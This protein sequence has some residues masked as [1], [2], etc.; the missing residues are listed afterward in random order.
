MKKIVLFSLLLSCLWSCQHA[1][2]SYDQTALPMSGNVEIPD[3]GLAFEENLLETHLSKLKI[4]KTGAITMEVEDFARARLQLDSMIDIHR[5][6]VANEAANRLDDKMEAQVTIKLLPQQF[7]PFMQRIEPLAIRV[8]DRSI[9]TKD[10][11]EEYTDSKARLSAREDVAQRYKDILKQ[12]NTV[13]EILS[14]EAKLG[15]VLE[16]I[17]SIKG[18]IRYLDEQVGWSTLTV[19]LFEYLPV[20]DVAEAGFFSKLGHAF[21][22]GWND[23]QRLLLD[24]AANWH[25]CLFWGLVIFAV[26]WFG[27][28]S[29]WSSFRMRN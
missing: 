12:A 21:T 3:D 15:Y 29:W 7:Y 19:T 20:K 6:F 24:L 9:Q 26:R 4:I 11:T 5:G 10:V 13:D 23:I 1:P 28:F 22:F 27:G 25:W 18:R 14:V 2:E 8:N 17:E 16:E